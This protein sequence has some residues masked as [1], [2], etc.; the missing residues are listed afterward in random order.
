MKPLR[1]GFLL[2]GKE[3]PQWQYEIL[4]R[5]ENTSNLE[6]SLIAFN[7]EF[8]ANNKHQ[9]NLN[10]TD[11][12]SASS[13]SDNATVKLAQK[14]LS[15]FRRAYSLL[16]PFAYGIPSLYHRFDEKYNADLKHLWKKKA[17]DA[18]INASKIVLQPIRKGFTHYFNETDIQ[19]IK[20]NDLDVIIRFG[21]SIIRGDI[22]KTAR[23]GIWSFH[24]GDN[25]FYRGGPPGIWELI[26]GK[27]E[28]AVTL[29]QLSDV[30]DCGNTIGRSTHRADLYSVL[31]NKHLIYSS[32]GDL[33]LQKLQQAQS[34]GFESIKNTALFKEDIPDTKILKS[35][36]NFEC[37]SLLITLI[38]NYIGLRWPRNKKIRWFL[39]VKPVDK[40]FDQFDHAKLITSPKDRFYADPFIISVEQEPKKKKTFIFF[41]ELIYTQKKAHI[42][43]GELINEELINIKPIIQEEFHLSYPY[44]F[45]DNGDWFLIPES[46]QNKTVRLYKCTDFPYQWQL[47]S[48]IIED[49]EL[50][51]SSIHKQDGTYF[52]FANKYQPNR[53]T[54]N[55]C[56][57]VYFSDSLTGEWHAH[58]LNPLVTNITNSRPAGK[59]FEHDGKLIL[60]TQNCALRY[61]YA[62]NFNEIEISK[63]HFSMKRVSGLSPDWHKNN[64]G[65]H[66]WNSDGETVVI[67]GH[68]YIDA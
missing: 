18:H 46:R 36:R 32:C 25:R 19:T 54:S 67:D 3:C 49:I 39:A 4:K 55:E 28:I 22:H 30:L 13:T 37:L 63:T 8:Q 11:S 34:M 58:P 48:I 68:H 60:P 43:V 17:I 1:I 6:V 23:L 16:N 41:E 45:K 24:H 7:G 29:Q 56:L 15:P 26:K 52:L 27:P 14:I 9:Q 65:S 35:P 51:D 66:T 44:T 33:L 47:E 12:P 38:K 10:D 62:I 20:D 5:V 64:L 57:V 50:L 53:D 42:S 40:H 59:L 21:F 61:G 31:K 2:Q